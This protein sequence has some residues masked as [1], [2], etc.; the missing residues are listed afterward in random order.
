M[1]AGWTMA[2]EVIVKVMEGGE[3]DDGKVGDGD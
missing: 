1:R 3:L 2:R